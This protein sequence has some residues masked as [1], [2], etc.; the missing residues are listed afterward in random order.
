VAR[1][2]GQARVAKAQA[3]VRQAEQTYK[4]LRTQIRSDVRR[5][6][7]RLETARLR[8]TMYRDSIIPSERSR[9]LYDA[10]AGPKAWLVIPAT[11]HNTL[12]VPNVFWD[13]VAG[14]LAAR[15]Q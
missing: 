9:A 15:T 13:G 7:A 2:D 12:S 5:I 11:D 10:W 3:Q 4:A 8:A 6:C 1:L 14:F